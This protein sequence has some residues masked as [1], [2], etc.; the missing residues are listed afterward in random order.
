M[1]DKSK[2]ITVLVVIG[3][4]AYLR[5]RRQTAGDVE[6]IIFAYRRFRIRWGQAEAFEIHPA[7]SILDRI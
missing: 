3:I 2:I 5:S 6:I 4:A 7:I 1:A